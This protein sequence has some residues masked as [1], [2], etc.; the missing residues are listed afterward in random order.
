MHNAIESG[1]GQEHYMQVQSSVFEDE[2]E[3]EGVTDVVS[4]ITLH[5]PLFRYFATH[6]PDDLKESWDKASINKNEARKLEAQYRRFHTDVRESLSQLDPEALTAL[7]IVAKEGDVDMAS[8]IL[9][10]YLARKG[11][12]EE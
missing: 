5:A 8:R 6:L 2:I 4:F 9:N 10:E 7:T 11:R 3:N 12:I 1:G